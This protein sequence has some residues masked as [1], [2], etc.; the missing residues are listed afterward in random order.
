MKYPHLLRKG[1]H[2]SS[3]GHQL[4]DFSAGVTGSIRLVLAALSLHGVGESH[5]RWDSGQKCRKN[6][7]G[8]GGWPWKQGTNR[9][10]SIKEKCIKI[11]KEWGIN[12]NKPSIRDLI[13]INGEYCGLVAQPTASWFIP[14]Y[15][16]IYLSIYV[17]L[18]FVGWS[19]K[20]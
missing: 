6:V 15:I 17:N 11:I 3:I 9:E 13:S 14:E 18:R 19:T 8:A 7:F 16:Y 20:H 1:W 2:I 4:G 5:E 10:L 12:M